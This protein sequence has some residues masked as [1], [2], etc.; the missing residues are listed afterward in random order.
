MSNSNI[1]EHGK[2]TQFT[3]ENQPANRGRKVSLRNELRNLLSGDS[4]MK[5]PKDQ[6]VR[7]NKDGSVEVRL[8]KKQM[9]AMKLITHA[10]NGSGKASD[11]I[12]AIKLM[13]EHI[14]GKPK[15]TITMEDPE[16]ILPTMFVDATGPN[17]PKKSKKRKK[18]K[19][20]E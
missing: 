7:K 8:P 17:K 14:D 20:D 19:A 16:D 18:G 5:I 2:A 3:S 13:F 6:V 11:S 9:L 12:A 4:T 1:A 10:L 15:Q